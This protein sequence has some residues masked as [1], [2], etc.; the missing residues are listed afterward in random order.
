MFGGGDHGKV[1]IGEDGSDPL[2]PIP[3]GVA[4]NRAMLAQSPRVSLG[5]PVF[6]GER[7]LAQAL[8]S[9]LAQTFTDFEII[10][11]D[12]ASAD[13]TAD[14]AQHYAAGDARIH[15]HRNA[16]NIGAAG[17]FNR[18][19]ALARGAYF[20]WCAH[21][22]LIAPDFLSRCVAVLDQNP[23][24]V[25]ACT[26]VQVI[27]EK[28]QTIG[29]HIADLPGLASPRPYIRFGQFIRF[30][31]TCFQ[32]FGLFRRDVLAQT[33]LIASHLG[34][35]KTLMAEI[36]LRGRVHEIAEPLFFSRQHPE[37]SVKLARNLL[38]GWYDTTRQ[39]RRVLPNWQKLM[40]YRRAIGRAPL[41]ADERLRCLG[42]LL[43]W[44]GAPNNWA[45]LLLDPIIALVPGL[46]DPLW[47]LDQRLRRQR[48][49]SPRYFRYFEDR[50]R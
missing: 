3:R 13:A 18:A 19:F 45:R 21:D 7:Y 36:C 31:P 42:Q 48:G 30:F 5:L 16:A 29:A 39:G 46:W 11:V 49:Y 12:N 44:V 33:P 24:V 32:V 50:T 27:D 23:D 15:Y 9:L 10:I 40:A 17:N 1:G 6:E 26:R 22:D 4:Y 25:L 2:L 20:K 8:D 34:S 43:L 28:G 41:A 37:R 47:R 14:I 38:A 35:D